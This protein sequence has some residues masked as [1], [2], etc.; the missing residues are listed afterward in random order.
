MV[1]VFKI[2]LDKVA[3]LSSVGLSIREIAHYIGISED[4]F[5]RRRNEDPAIDEAIQQGR[6]KGVSEVAQALKKRAVEDCDP[7][8]MKLFLQSLGE[9]FGKKSTLAVEAV[10][11]ICIK[12]TTA[13]GTTTTV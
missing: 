4:T 5:K 6:S 2:D 9:S 13:D 8:A 3:E 7:Q 11:S 10:P 12:L 1:R